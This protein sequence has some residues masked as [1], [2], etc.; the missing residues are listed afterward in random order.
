MRKECYCVAIHTVVAGDTLYSISQIYDV[1]VCDLM[2]AN[3]I[4]NPYNLRIGMKLCIPGD[5]P[6]MPPNNQPPQTSPHPPQMDNNHD[7]NC[8]CMPKECKGTPYTVKKGDTLY[9]IAKAYRIPL[10]ALMDANPDIDPYNM[11]VGMEICIPR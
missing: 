8:D 10:N 5:T 11:Y 3:K 9:L 1:S 7:D 2:M 4:R 6:V